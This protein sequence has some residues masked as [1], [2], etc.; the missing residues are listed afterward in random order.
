MSNIKAYKIKIVK[1]YLKFHKF[2]LVLNSVNQSSNKFNSFKKTILKSG[3][4]ILK[5]SSNVLNINLNNSIFDFLSY[6]FIKCS[7][8][9][10]LINFS[11]L[12]KTIIFNKKLKNIYSVIGLKFNNKLYSLTSFNFLL[13]FN[14]YQSKKSLFQFFILNLKIIVLRERGI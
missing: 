1:N 3:L 11:L 7:I 5:I 6:K 9:F 12:Y 10:L 4:N 2:V 13:S 8:L 14:Y